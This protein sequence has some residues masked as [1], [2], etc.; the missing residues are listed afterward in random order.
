MFSEFLNGGNNNK[1]EQNCCSENN[2]LIPASPADFPKQRVNQRCVVC[3]Y[4]IHLKKKIK[5]II[6]YWKSV[7]QRSKEANIVPVRWAPPHWRSLRQPTPA[8]QW[9]GRANTGE[10]KGGTNGDGLATCREEEELWLVLCVHR[11]QPVHTRQSRR[12][13]IS[14]AFPRSQF[15]MHNFI[16]S[17]SSA[18][19]VRVWIL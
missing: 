17:R 3:H 14:P 13:E 5:K 7:K 11:N 10:F 12:C 16:Y 1:W 6:L 2:K 15:K 9:G 19:C 8:F 18:G 4:V